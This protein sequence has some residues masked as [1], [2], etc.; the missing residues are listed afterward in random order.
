MKKGT[1]IALLVAAMLILCGGLISGLGMLAERDRRGEAPVMEFTEESREISDKFTRIALDTGMY[2]VTLER[3]SD[4]VGRVVY[5]E[6]KKLSCTISVKN[7]VL[8]IEEQD[9]RGV[10]DQF[11]FFTSPALTIYLPETAFDSLHVESTTG[12]LEVPAAFSFGDL[13]YEGDTGDVS[14]MAEIA[15]SLELSTDTGMITVADVTVG[16]MEIETDTG[17]IS[18]RKLTVQDE[19]EISG[20]TCGVRMEDVTARTLELELSTGDVYC[21]GLNV[22]HKLDMESST[23]HKELSSV[24][25]YNLVLSAT[26][27]KTVLQD[28]VAE[29]SAV[30]T[31]DT[32]D[33]E[34]EGFDAAEIGI[35]TST[36]DVS[37]WFLSDKVIFAESDTGDIDIAESLSGG[38]CRVTTDTG[39]ISLQIGK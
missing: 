8:L 33:I 16:R 25:C 22:E 15:D 18:L 27:G 13:S 29:G 35:V 32:G 31:A 7:G 37:G 38:K 6:S 2:D 19:V 34:L 26:T 14:V 12:D 5:L 30:L 9:K 23:G 24:R 21:D 17:D 1:K 39:D 4:G 3:A 28:V 11:N 36:G 20:D 10:M